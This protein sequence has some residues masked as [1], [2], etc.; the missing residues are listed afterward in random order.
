VPG[1]KYRFDRL[2]EKGLVQPIAYEVYPY[3]VEISANHKVMLEFTTT[4]A[5]NAF[6]SLTPKLFFILGV[7]KVPNSKTVVMRTYIVES[8][9][10]KMFRFFSRM[11]QGGMIG[12]YSSLRLQFAGRERR[13]IPVELFD[14]EKG[15]VVDKHQCLR[16]LSK[17]ISATNPHPIPSSVKGHSK[18]AASSS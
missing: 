5:M 8:Q 13:T 2:A 18:P 7:G 9:L 4:H 3:P 1:V 10:R 6:L 16:K 14:D 17:L 11:A 12:S 15:W